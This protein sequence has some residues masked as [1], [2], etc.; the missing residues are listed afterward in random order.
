[1]WGN[2]SPVTVRPQQALL[3]F[4]TGLRERGL[5]AALSSWFTPDT[6]GRAQEIQ[7]PD[8]LARVWTETLNVIDDAGLLEVVEWVDLCNEWPL[9]MKSLHQQIWPQNQDL[10][11]G[12]YLSW[13][14]ADVARV[15]SYS[16]AL[17]AVKAAAPS[18]PATFSYCTRGSILPSSE[19]CMRLDT[20]AYDL[21]EVHLWLHSQEEFADDT[22]LSGSDTTG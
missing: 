5:T 11:D 6:T 19:D 15:D 4:L 17:R 13:S 16:A 21:A 14:D 8:D 18:L 2:H 20:R 12:R 1:M 10:V 7:I 22:E 3:E 9:W